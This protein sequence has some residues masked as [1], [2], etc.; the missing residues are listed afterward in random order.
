V[1]HS[2]YIASPN[3]GS[4]FLDRLQGDF[5]ADANGVE[6]LVNLQELSQKGIAAKPGKS[7][8]DY[9]YF[10]NENPASCVVDSGLPS[11]FRLDDPL[12]TGIYQASCA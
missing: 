7:I 6:S 3:R 8:V 2:Y 4:S 9:I 1:Y 10:S 5:S 11:W 12:H